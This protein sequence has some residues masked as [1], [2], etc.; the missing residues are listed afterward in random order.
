MPNQPHSRSA[1]AARRSHIL[2]TLLD[3]HR[4]ALLRQALSHSHRPADAEDALQDACVQFLGHYDG[5]PGTDALRWMLLVVK[6]CAWAIGSSQRRHQ[7][8]VE[9][10]ATDAVS[11]EEAPVLIPA[12][13]ADLDPAYLAERHEQNAERLAA[14]G[15]LKPDERTA[16]G[17][18][19]AGYS[20]REIG[21]R[22]EWTQTKVNRCLAEGR[23]ALQ[24]DGAAT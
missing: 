12:A 13:D 10:S 5:P 16:I 9:L 21:E 6:R 7:A 20:Y 11:D 15:R 18:Q 23:A 17:L 4:P 1:G 8:S 22:Q 2:T 19:A 3:H 24:A 14:L